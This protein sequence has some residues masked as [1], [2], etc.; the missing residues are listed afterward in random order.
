MIVADSSVWIAALRGASSPAVEQFHL[1][2]LE[3]NI[4]VGDLILLEVLQGA[5]SEPHAALLERS[6][7]RHPVV[8]LLEGDLPARAAAHYRS[9]TGRGITVRKTVDLIIATYCLERDHV[10]LHQDR[11]YSHFATYLGLRVL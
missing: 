1:A 7:Q 5:R 8:S 4:L 2:A 11:D 6:M 9:L 10:L 3:G